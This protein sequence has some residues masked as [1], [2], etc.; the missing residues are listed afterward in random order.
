MRPGA[1]AACRHRPA[2]RYVATW[3]AALYLVPLPRT[4]R[5]RLEAGIMGSH[6]MRHGIKMR[7]VVFG[8]LPSPCCF[9]ILLSTPESALS[10][11]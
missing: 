10:A 6:W 9:C 7:Q 5:F 11:P 8:S 3:L 1:Y 2:W 4:R